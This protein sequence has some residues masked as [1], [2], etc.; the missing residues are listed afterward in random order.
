MRTLLTPVEDPSLDDADWRLLLDLTARAA[1]EGNASP[2]EAVRGLVR[3]LAGPLNAYGEMTILAVRN[4]SAPADDPLRGFRAGAVLISGPGMRNP[5]LAERFLKDELVKD[6]L[7]RWLTARAGQPRVQRQSTAIE[8]RWA[9]TRTADFMRRVGHGDHLIAGCPLHRTVEVYVS[10]VRP[11]GAA[12]FD[13]HDQRLLTEALPVLR[14]WCER[15][16]QVFGLFPGQT[17]LSRRERQAVGLLFSAL[18]EKALAHELG[19]S[20]GT[21]H[22]YVVSIYRKLG[23]GS[24]QE[25]LVRGAPRPYPALERER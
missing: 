1:Q 3:G 21:A 8:A 16:A 20:V 7:A 19:L 6:E 10:F 18:S 15:W 22:Q 5:R 13:E 17:P 11:V 9:E 2:Q 24:R 4:L 12:P 25:L 23:V 14:P